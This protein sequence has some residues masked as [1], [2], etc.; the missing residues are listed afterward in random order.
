MGKMATPQTPEEFTLEWVSPIINRYFEEKKGK[1]LSKIQ[2]VDVKAEKNCLQGILSTT[3][4]V[5]V[6]YKDENPPGK[7]FSFGT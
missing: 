1:D 3:F 5:D 7:E 6:I 2:I 4:V